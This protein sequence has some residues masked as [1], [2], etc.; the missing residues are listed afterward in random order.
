MEG[1]GE[2]A[3]LGFF[4]TTP[5]QFSSHHSHQADHK[6][7]VSPVPGHPIPSSGLCLIVPATLPCDVQVLVLKSVNTSPVRHREPCKCSL[8]GES[9]RCELNVISG[10]VPSRPRQNGEA[11]RLEAGAGETPVLLGVGWVLGSRVKSV[12]SSG[13]QKGKETHRFSPTVGHSFNSH[14]YKV[15][16]LCYFAALGLFLSSSK[17]LTLK[18]ETVVQY[19]NT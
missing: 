9:K 8:N 4:Q 10:S 13:S 11:V 2:K 12:E 1:A 18:W 7:P 19:R 16:H 17:F 3:G 5:V 15:I 6:L 14:N